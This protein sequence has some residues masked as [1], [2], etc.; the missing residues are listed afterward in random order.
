MIAGEKTSCSNL[1]RQM[2]L[3]RL[4]LALVIITNPRLVFNLKI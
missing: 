1:A 2:L 4:Q 3:C